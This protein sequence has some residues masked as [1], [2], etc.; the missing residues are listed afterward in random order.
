MTSY[1]LQFDTF[2]RMPQGTCIHEPDLGP[3]RP[4]ALSFVWQA[5]GDARAYGIKQ[6]YIVK[7]C[8]LWI[9]TWWGTWHFD[10]AIERNPPSRLQ[11]NEAQAAFE[12]R[13]RSA[14]LNRQWT[15]ARQSGKSK[16]RRAHKT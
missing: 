11:W 7:P 6:D 2:D 15:G 16:P 5:G 4:I 9:Y 8:R 3:W 13:Q 10:F 12:L 1:Q 14:E